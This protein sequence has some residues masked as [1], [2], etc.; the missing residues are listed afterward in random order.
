MSEE[1]RKR[2]GVRQGERRGRAEEDK[3]ASK[4]FRDRTGGGEYKTA[5]EKRAPEFGVG[6]G[7]GGGSGAS[8]SVGG[9]RS[10]APK[11]SCVTCGKLLAKSSMKKHVQ[12]YHA[13]HVPTTEPPAGLGEIFAFNMDTMASELKDMSG[14]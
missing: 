2:R 4:A 1:C 7:G 14:F 10:G 6:S 11:V 3:A 8:S 5:A 13:P 9:G 12:T